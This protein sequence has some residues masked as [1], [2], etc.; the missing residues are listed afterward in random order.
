MFAFMRAA[1]YAGVCHMTIRRRQYSGAG[2]IA[3]ARIFEGNFS[4]P[5]DWLDVY[6][7]AALLANGVLN[8]ERLRRLEIY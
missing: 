5:S 4:P 7:A 6:P 2:R 8:S 3:F 1:G